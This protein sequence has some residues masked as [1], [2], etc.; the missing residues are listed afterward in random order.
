MLEVVKR[1]IDGGRGEMKGKAPPPMTA[2]GVV[3]A[4]SSV[5]HARLARHARRDSIAELLGP[6]MGMIVMPYLGAAAAMR[7][8]ERPRPRR[9]RRP[10]GA[11]HN[12]LRDLDMRLTYRT[13]RVLMAISQ[14]PGA[15]NRALAEA[16]GVSDQG[17]ISKLLSRLKTLG[18]VEN[19]GRGPVKGEPN[20]WQL[21]D[22]GQ[23]VGQ[24]ISLQT[25]T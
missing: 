4:V 11:G 7:E 19:I 9:P 15:S 8:I 17:Q 10:R 6:L 1:A 16:A 21:T 23:Q 3:G 20:A 14:T 18:L 12:T 25:Q 5:L 2:E 22:K 24:A 13:V